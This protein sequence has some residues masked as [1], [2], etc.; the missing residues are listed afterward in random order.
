MSTTPQQRTLQQSRIPPPQSPPQQSAPVTR[1]LGYVSAEPPQQRTLQ[2]SRIPPP[3]SP[4]QQ[5]APVTR[6][7]GY[8]SAS[9]FNN[10]HYNNR[11][12]HLHNPHHNNL[13][14]LRGAW[15][16]YQRNPSTTNTTTIENSTTTPTSITSTIETCDDGNPIPSSGGNMPRRFNGILF[17]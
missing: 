8:V 13:L 3:Q 7:L 14:R 15:V 9:T 4:P 11:E 1:C 17:G 16:M 12:F 10:E 6:C 2:Q 5:S